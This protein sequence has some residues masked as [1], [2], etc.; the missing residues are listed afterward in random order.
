M[1]SFFKAP[2]ALLALFGARFVPTCLLLGVV[3]AS[4][5]AV[6]DIQTSFG[7]TEVRALMLSLNGTIARPTR[8]MMACRQSWARTS[9]FL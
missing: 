2:G 8:F 3:W 6:V 4:E 5:S 9:K 1:F 7:L